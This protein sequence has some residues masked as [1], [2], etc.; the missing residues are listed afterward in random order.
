MATQFDATARI[1]VDLRGFASAANEVT[2][3]GGAMS[4]VFSNMHQQLN[5]LEIVEKKHAAALRSTLGVYNQ[6][7]TVA[8][9]Y[10]TAISSLAKN[11]QAG[12]NGA[13]LMA[14]AMG[15]LR[16]ALSGVQGMSSK[17]AERLGRTVGLY[18]QLASAL[19]KVARAYQIIRSVSQVDRGQAQAAERQAQ[20]A[21]RLAVEQQR[22]EAAALRAANAQRRLNA[23]LN[24]SAAG[25]GRFSG[26]TYAMR[27][28]LGE[29]ESQ[30]LQ[31]I[32][33]FQQIGVALAGSAISQE[34]AFAQVARVVGEAE[35]QSAGLLESFR[36]MA[37]EFPISFEEVAR[38]GQLGA[39]IGVTAGELDAFT[40][41]V[42]K[43]SLTTGV[44]ADQAT[45]LLGRIAEM[46]D[47]PTS[48]MENLGSAILDLGTKSAATEDEILRVNESIAT[49]SNVF[50]LSAQAVTGLASAL[51][52]LRVR[53]ELARGSLTRVFGEMD[54]AIQAGDASLDQLAVTMGMTADEVVKLRQTNPDEFFLAFVR[55]LSEAGTETGNF[56][57]ILRALGINAVRDID[58]FTRLANNF[59]V[60]SNSFR[61]SNAA[62]SE[63]TELQ[64]QFQGIAETTSAKLQNLADAFKNLLAVGGDALLP[65]ISKIADMFTFLIDR[66]TALGPVVPIMGALTAAVVV[67][68]GAWLVYRVAVAK[69]IQAGLAMS[70]LQRSLQGRTLGVAT[71]YAALRGRLDTVA[72]STR[73]AAAGANSLAAA[74][75]AAAA[76]GV[77]MTRSTSSIATA[78]RSAATNT[79]P[80]VA[81]YQNASRTASQLSTTSQRLGTT[82][83]ALNNATRVSVPIMTNMSG[84]MQRAAIAG[85]AM[86]SGLTSAQA[87]T[88]GLNRQLAATG[89]AATTAAAGMTLASRAG[90]LLMASLGPI[91]LALTVATLAWSFFG[92]SAEEAVDKVQ[93]AADN[94]WNAAGGIESL[95]AALKEDTAAWREQGSPVKSAADS[96]RV[97]SA[98]ADQLSKKNKDTLQDL[99]DQT[100]ALER[101]AVASYGS[102]D[103]MREVAR[104]GGAAGEAAAKLAKSYDEAAAALERAN[105]AANNSDIFVGVKSAQK[106]QEALQK[107]VT[108]ADFTKSNASMEAFIAT[109]IKLGDVMAD[110]GSG[111]VSQAIKQFDAPLKNANKSLAEA[112]AAADK[113][114]EAYRKLGSTA[115]AELITEALANVTA[116]EA[117]RAAA[118]QTVDD[119]K[120]LQKVVRGGESEAQRLARAQDVLSQSTAKS[121]DAAAAAGEDISAQAEAMAELA[122]AAEQL[123]SKLNDAFGPLSAWQ[124]AADKAAAGSNNLS[125]A[126]KAAAVS[127]GDLLEEMRK[128]VKAQEEWAD[129]MTRVAARVPQDVANE[130]AQMGPESA[131][132]I[133]KL[134]DATDAELKE[135]VELFRKNGASG[136]TALSSALLNSIPALAK[137]GDQVGAEAARAMGDALAR[138]LNAGTTPAKFDQ[139]IANYEALGKLISSKEIKGKVAIDILE[140]Q[141]NITKI[142]E[143]VAA[144]MASGDLDIDVLV[145]LSQLGFLDGVTAL[146][147]TITELNSSGQL[148]LKAD[149]E[150]SRDQY[151]RTMN[152]LTTINKAIKDQNLLDVLGKADLDISQFLTSADSIKALAN[153]L[154]QNREVDANGNATLDVEGFIEDLNKIKNDVSAGEERSDY[155]PQGSASLL[156]KGYDEKLDRLERDVKNAENGPLDPEGAARLVNGNFYTKL[157]NFIGA[158]ANAGSQIQRNLT[159]TATV[160]ILYQVAGAVGAAAGA[161]YAKGGWING[162]GGPTSDAV[163]AMLSNGEFVVAAKQAQ[164]FG[165]LLEDINSGRAGRG[166]TSGVQRTSGGVQAFGPVS[167]RSGDLDKAMDRALIRRLPS[168]SQIV[169]EM[170]TPQVV[171]G[172]PV[173]NIT[174]QYPQAEPTSTTINR[175][176]AYAATISGV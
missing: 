152:D 41:T 174:N 36:Q 70:E 17:E 74:N 81:A 14:Q 62:W 173:I 50:G 47:V 69:A 27:S 149:A 137:V 150:L 87:A 146:K 12:A 134:A 4:R 151:V 160:T 114:S 10:A 60:V 19:Q 48:Q 116:A 18:N 129:N 21:R 95:T 22:V 40:R 56:Q 77:A 110:L 105:K 135:Y 25:M 124:A 148:N 143:V 128:Q 53:P 119:L 138:D 103:A 126:Q 117:R 170:G 45:L 133:A 52:T 175:S 38:I 1:N 49:V 164:R 171:G 83:T 130:L 32:R 75:R 9:S 99:R 159:R 140:A 91:G 90:R 139:V 13:R 104:Q 136:A 84:S 86:G 44:A 155:S 23:E 166:F 59:D 107:A 51:A 161:G 34:R 92:S 157:S 2:K 111:N 162:P 132:I 16:S 11:E 35:A 57:Q 122:Q 68:G 102:V 108:A 145:K 26:S 39:Q 106:L 7:A 64:R 156:T 55:G 167:L 15:Q 144:A 176:L 131:G 172:G 82:Q 158:A 88:L 80:V 169:R 46:Q 31:L 112:K 66:M 3:S 127:M 100:A 147:G 168:V 37:E 118:Q 71:A 165:A 121:G 33:V 85:N 24:A 113:A 20:A 123:G 72:S 76:S 154:Q 120:A 30:G 29:L 6:A 142:R 65:V 63:G 109:G 67:G 98:T 28:S 94:A 163:P 141:G 96:L 125:E 8:R 58:T 89:A 42:A 153:A 115:S 73:T 79:T 54:A 93:E 43:F 101:Q 5:Q 97:Y 78:M 61:D